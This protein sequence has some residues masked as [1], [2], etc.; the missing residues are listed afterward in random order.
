MIFA[1]FFIN[2]YFIINSIIKI[3]FDVYGVSC[4]KKYGFYYLKDK[5]WNILLI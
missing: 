5:Y 4:S 3:V 2:Q 1:S